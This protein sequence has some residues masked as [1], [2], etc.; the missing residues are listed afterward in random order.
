[1]NEESIGQSQP[2][3]GNDGYPYA[4]AGPTPIELEADHLVGGLDSIDLMEDQPI[5]PGRPLP[6]DT[7]PGEPTPVEITEAL[8]NAPS[9]TITIDFEGKEI[10]VVELTFANWMTYVSIF[11]PQFESVMK[12]LL[13]LVGVATK[14]F[15]VLRHLDKK[16]QAVLKEI[17]KTGDYALLESTLQGLGASDY[18]F[19]DIENLVEASK[20][21]KNLDFLIAISTLLLR[22][23]GG[24][25]LKALEEMSFSSI[26][27]NLGKDLPDLAFA[28]I[29]SSYKRRGEEFAEKELREQIE[30]MDG[31]DMFDIVYKQYLLY[32]QRGKVRRFFDQVVT[33]TMKSIGTGTPT[34]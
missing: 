23:L 10:P 2:D 13:P 27:T 6:G 8:T 33:M 28:S 34:A 21:D 26:V 30:M 4:G 31:M 5:Q 29:A 17:A 20:K 32:S 18:S 16:T 15:S 14:S 3:D 19:D 9:K 12:N 7:L 24:P 25:A 1:M 22:P 11:A